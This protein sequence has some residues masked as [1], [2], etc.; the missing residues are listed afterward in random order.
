MSKWVTLK[1]SDGFELKAYVAEP[2]GKPKGGLVVVQE[3]FGVNAHIRSVTDRFAAEGYLAVAPAIFDRGEPGAELAYDKAGFEKGYALLKKIPMDDTMKDVA[4]ALDYAAKETGKP[5][6]VVGFCYGGSLAWRAAAEL[7]TAA[8][9]GYYGGFIIKYK[10]ETPKA[11]VML[12]F[13]KKDEHIP[14]SDV[15]QVQAL[16]PEVPVYWY[17]AGHAFNRDGNQA[18]VEKAA[19]EAMTRTLAFFAEHV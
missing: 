7:S 14:E 17:D 18:Y 2:A 4:A 19:K 11:P 15:A 6:G 10:D 16:H 5:A 8:A 13:G 3:I 12:H 1:A 9:V